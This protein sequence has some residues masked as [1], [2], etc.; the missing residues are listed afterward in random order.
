MTQRYIV[1]SGSDS[2]HCCFEASVVDTTRPTMFGAEHYH[3]NGI[4]SYH[5]VCECFEEREAQ[6]IAYTL[7]KEHER[8]TERG[9]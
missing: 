6:N 8:K 4:P 3:R 2:G 9:E 1:Q 7:N 5:C